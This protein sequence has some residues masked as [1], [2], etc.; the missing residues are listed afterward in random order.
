LSRRGNEASY[1]IVELSAD[2][3]ARQRTTIA[4]LAPQALDR[5][6]WLNQLPSTFKG[7]ILGNELIDAMPVRLFRLV[8]DA[9]GAMAKLERR[10]TLSD[11]DNSSFAW[12]DV[13]ADVVFQ[14][15][16]DI[17]L[18]RANWTL[19]RMDG[20]TSELPLQG[21]AWLA[22]V[23]RCLE[24]GVILLLDYGFSAQE[25][26]HPQRSQGTLICHY[27]HH[28]HAEPFYL[29]GLQDITAHVDFSA[30]LDEGFSHG[31]ELLGYTNQAHFLMNLQMLDKLKAM[32]D[33]P[34]YPLHAQAVGRLLSEAEMG[35]LFKVIAFAKL[36]SG[37]AFR[38]L[39]FS[40]GDK[41]HTL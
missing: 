7:V 13:P 4:T 11:H 27:R 24:Q 28:S 23:A 32:Q 14:K 19:E 40:H 18:E 41:S 30:L 10:V 37:R 22:S 20:F 17:A 12:K 16:I 29:P 21:N 15:E 31:L 26:Y 39:G 25:F 33:S 35:D 34:Q 3:Q 5:V 38:S 36:E 6:V 8:H 2:L 9:S 1:A